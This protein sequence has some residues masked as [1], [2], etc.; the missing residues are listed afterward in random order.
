MKFPE[1][2]EPEHS[3]SGG[4]TDPPAAIR[5]AAEHGDVD[6]PAIIWTIRSEQMPP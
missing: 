6:A 3:H 5:R 1:I 4:V 2:A